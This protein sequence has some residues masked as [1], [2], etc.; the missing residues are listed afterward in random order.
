MMVL[1]QN[2][3]TDQA[4]FLRQMLVYSTHS[5]HDHTGMTVYPVNGTRTSYVEI[6]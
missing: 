4:P 6:V 3:V 5:S 1:R 2:S